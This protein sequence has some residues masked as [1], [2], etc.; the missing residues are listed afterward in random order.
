MDEMK[1]VII[2][3]I[4]LLNITKDNNKDIININYIK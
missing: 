2:M 3:R 4:V 1:E